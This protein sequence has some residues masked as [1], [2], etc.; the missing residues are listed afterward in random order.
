MLIS[1]LRRDSLRDR[2]NFLK[3]NFIICIQRDMSR[4]P[5]IEGPLELLN[6]GLSHLRSGSDFDLRIAMISI[7]N[8]VELMIKTYLGL[9]KRITGIEGLS[10]QRYEE[11]GQNFSSLLDAIEKFAPAKI[12]GIELGDIEWFHRIRNQL[13]HEGNGITVEKEK[14]EA[15]AEIASILFKN[16]FETDVEEG[17]KKESYSLVG[18]FLNNWANLERELISIANKLGITTE[19]QFMSPSKTINQLRHNKVISE[20]L[21]E[22]FLASRNFRNQLV[23]HAKV[24]SVK[25]L[26]IEN[27]NLKELLREIIKLH[28]SIQ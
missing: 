3:G 14:V 24:P 13:Y 4:K 17:V 23:H 10:K 19:P 9:P 6:H 26:Q 2:I 20:S 8:A 15:Y 7:D 22:K 27:A 18:E 21:A 25:E 12:V 16:L 5:W 28:S 1:A 11:I